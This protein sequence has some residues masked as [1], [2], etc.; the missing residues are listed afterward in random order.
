MSPSFTPPSTMPLM[1]FPTCTTPNSICINITFFLTCF[2]AFLIGIFAPPFF[3]LYRA[4][5][6]LFI[7]DLLSA[8]YCC[9]IEGMYDMFAARTG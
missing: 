3:G 9:S 6:L 4:W 2:V 1:P 7:V 8:V 5:L